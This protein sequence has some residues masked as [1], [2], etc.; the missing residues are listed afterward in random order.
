[1]HNSVVFWSQER[2]SMMHC[3]KVGGLAKA[4]KLHTSVLKPLMPGNSIDFLKKTY[5]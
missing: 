1:M 4:N 2:Y 3:G 5:I